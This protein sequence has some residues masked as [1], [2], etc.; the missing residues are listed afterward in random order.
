MSTPQLAA[1]P[2]TRQI[3]GPGMPRR[4]AGA[5]LFLATAATAAATVACWWLD[6]RMSV[7]SLAMVYLVAVAVVALFADRWAG[8]YASLVSVTALNYFFVPPRYTFDVS[9]PEYWWT[10]AVLLALSLGIGALIARLREGRARA[11]EREHQSLQLHELSEA[12][13]ACDGPVAAVSRAAEWMS[14]A[15]NQPCAVFLAGASPGALRCEPSN[16]QAAFKPQP[17]EWAIDNR[18]PLGRGCPDWPDLPLWCCPFNRR[19]PMGCVQVLLG[20]RQIPSAETLE[21]WQALVRQIGLSVEREK[22]AAE[23]LQAQEAAR[24]E[25]TRNTL[26]A[27]L[28]HDLRT[29][30]SGIVGSA[31]ALREQGEAMTA[32]QRDK[33]LANLENEARD[34]SLMADNV[35]QMARLSQ[36]RWELKMQWESLE[37]ILGATLARMRRRWPEARIQLRVPAG[38]PPVQAEAGLLA[39]ALANLVD[40][41]VRHGGPG[42]GVTLQ[43]GRSRDG[44]FVA[45][46]DDG[47]GLPPG[48]PAE[49]FERYRRGAAESKADSGAAGLGLAICRNIVEAHGGRIEARRCEPGAE[50]RIDLPVAE[51]AAVPNE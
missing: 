45:V 11:E 17:A 18:R 5:Q 37:E 32:A 35:L 31:S 48:D 50:F 21:H 14:Q 41:A 15:V 28:S 46:R 7:A 26:L 40:N 39:Q 16:P 10:L 51:P 19:A 43:A 6:A 2:G 34:M 1:R 44:V 36:P 23:A 8:I 49:F 38:L 4:G 9:D 30:L 22:A 25:A 20:P 3:A 47:P 12:L 42:T 13:A 24:S 33:L 29:P 27:S